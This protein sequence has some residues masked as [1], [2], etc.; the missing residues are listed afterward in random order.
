ML[1]L[2]SDLLTNHDFEG[3]PMAGAGLKPVRRAPEAI[4][5]SL[6]RVLQEHQN[7]YET[8]RASQANYSNEPKSDQK[9]N[10]ASSGRLELD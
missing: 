4:K 2:K 5:I 3:I 9:Q 8:W 7:C 6:S 1:F 10:N